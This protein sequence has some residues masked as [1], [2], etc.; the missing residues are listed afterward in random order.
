MG[1]DSKMRTLKIWKIV[2]I[3]HGI[4]WFL[5]VYDC[6]IASI[7]DRSTPWDLYMD[8]I[9]QI[10]SDPPMLYSFV[11]T[12]LISNIFTIPRL[13]ALYRLIEAVIMGE[14]KL[15]HVLLYVLFFICECLRLW[16][17]YFYLSRAHKPVIYLYPETKTEVNVKLELDGK[18]TVVY[19]DYDETSGWT[20]T[21]EPDGTLTDKKGRQYS[22]LYWEGDIKIKPDMSAG[23]CVK[24]ED[25]AEFLENALRQ[26]GLNDKEAD[27]FITYWLPLMQGNKYNVITFQTKAYEDVAALRVSP[28]PDTVIRVN[29][30]WYASNAQIGIKPQDL[31]A[32]NPAERKG[33]TVVEWGGEE[34]KKDHPRLELMA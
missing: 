24:G 12:S 1:S 13:I 8:M 26:L 33:F 32:I 27:D 11:I 7:Q 30:L 17:L 31:T 14:R 21:A 3:I 5:R 9:R 4:L 20:V 22:Y 23:F 29:M 18:L 10:V 2:L 28:A 15:K 16:V 19:P 34:Y 25:T 6:L